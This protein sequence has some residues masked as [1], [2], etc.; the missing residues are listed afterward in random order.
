MIEKC[1][2]DGVRCPVPCLTAIM[3]VQ[4]GQ[5]HFKNLAV[6]AKIFKVCLTILGHELPC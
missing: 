6:F 3:N 4:N 5:T 2:G 1:E